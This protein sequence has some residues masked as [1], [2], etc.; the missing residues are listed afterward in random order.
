MKKIILQSMLALISA[1]LMSIDAMAADG[2]ITGITVTPMN[3][4]PLEAITVVV[5]GTIAPGK[6]CGI[7]FVKGDGTPQS[8]MGHPTSFPFTFGGQ[9]YPL[10]VYN[11]PGTYTIKVYPDPY[12]KDA[13]CTGSGQ[14]TI[15]VSNPPPAP[16][17]QINKGFVTAALGPDPCPQGWHKTQG[18]ADGPFQCAPNKPTQKIQCPPKTQYFETE[19]AIGCQ[20]MLY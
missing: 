18:S 2:N 8:L 7:L 1:M 6:N 11:N 13:K 19:C 9:G 12:Q 20:Q 17:V 3:P 16:G 10:F 15:K 14:V 4:K 5:N